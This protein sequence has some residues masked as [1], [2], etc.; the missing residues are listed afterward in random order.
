MTKKVLIP[1]PRYGFDPTEV[2]VP[3][4]YLQKAG[5]TTVFAT[6]DGSIGKA[7]VRMVEGSGLGIFKPMLKAEPSAVKVYRE[8][9][10]SVEFKNP[11][12]YD[13][14]SNQEFD[15]VFLPGGHDKG[16][17]EYLESKFLQKTV[18]Q[19]FEENKPVA[20]I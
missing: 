20:A 9:E 3:W 10:N 8:L 5:V 1:I 7:D 12:A 15:A 17:R 18:A 4:Q 14:I 19:F 2:S 16:M 6:P 13:Q 11:I